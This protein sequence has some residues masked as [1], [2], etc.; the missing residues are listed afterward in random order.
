MTG[1]PLSALVMAGGRG[2]RMK[3]AGGG[4][5]KPLVPVRGVPLLERNL[6]MLLAAGFR[7]VWVAVSQHLPEVGRYVETRGAELA[8]AIGGSAHCLPEAQPLGTIGAAAALR[9]RTGPVLVLNADNLISFDLHAFVDHHVRNGAALTV[10]THFEPFRIP[11]GEVCTTDGRVTAYLEKPLRRVC[12]SSGTYV[13]SPESLELLPPGERVD[14]PWLVDRL[15]AQGRLVLSFPHESCW[16]D[17][18]DAASLQRAEEL[19]DAHPELV[20]RPPESPNVF[21]GRIDAAN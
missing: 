19:V 15:L 9:G 12:V 18:N 10:A 17:V 4:V 13:L 3:D 8:R 11:Y 14:V 16:I 5:P 2:E 1:E 6:L 7:D 21:P 20:A